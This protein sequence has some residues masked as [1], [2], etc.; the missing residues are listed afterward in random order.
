MTTSDNVLRIGCAWKVPTTSHSSVSTITSDIP[1][2]L[3]DIDMELIDPDGNVVA[4]SN[5]TYSNTEMIAFDVADYGVYGTYTIKVT[6]NKAS[7]YGPDG[8]RC[9]LA[10]Y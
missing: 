1:E 10:W 3:I 5:G 9:Y 8:V 4:T 6:A 2:V 7:T